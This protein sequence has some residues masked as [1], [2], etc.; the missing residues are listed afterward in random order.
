MNYSR[1]KNMIPSEQH[2]IEQ[3]VDSKK[4][5]SYAPKPRKVPKPKIASAR[6]KK[7]L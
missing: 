1:E 3:F 2:F 6:L 4:K 7:N 5:I